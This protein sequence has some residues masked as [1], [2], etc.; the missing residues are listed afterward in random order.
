VSNPVDARNPA[1]SRNCHSIRV[2]RVKGLISLGE[3]H[4][5]KNEAEERFKNSDGVCFLGWGLIIRLK[6]PQQRFVKRSRRSRIHAGWI[7]VTGRFI[8]LL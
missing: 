3:T 8:Q 6:R 7:T 5:L 4:V 1:Y 2:G